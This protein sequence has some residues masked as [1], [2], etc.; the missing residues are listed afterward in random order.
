MRAEASSEESISNLDIV[1]LAVYLLGGS[2]AVVDTEDV[3]IEANKLAPGRFTWRRHKSQIN[4]EHVRVRLSEAKSPDNGCLL[5]GDGATGWQLTRAGLEHALGLK[6]A[7]KG[8]AVGRPRSSRLEDRRRRAEIGRISTLPAWKKFSCGEAISRRE[9]EAVYRL[10]DYVRG[11][12]RQVLI[13]RVRLLFVRH[14]VY[15]EFINE[16]AR[17]AST[18]PASTEET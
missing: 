18:T 17:L 2:S 10:T 7:L 16:T 14:P 3:A 15:E 1:V 8:V 9:A 6:D 5:S 12:R 13:N 11:R 4:I